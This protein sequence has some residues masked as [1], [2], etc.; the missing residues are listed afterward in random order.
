MTLHPSPR[1]AGWTRRSFLQAVLGTLSLLS[2]GWI[3][4]RVFLPR[5]LRPPEVATLT[6]LVETLLPD[7]E[8]PGAVRTNVMAALLAEPRPT[9]QQRR[10]LVEG[11]QLL[12]SEARRRGAAG[13]TELKPEQR[14]DVVD[15][16]ARAEEGTLPRFFYRIVRDRAM[17]L[18]YANPI[19]WA[20]VRFPHPPQ[21][22]GYPA[23]WQKPDV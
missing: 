17:Q 12:D 6:V 13:F 3:L 7:G 8:F 19:A 1:L 5:S 11:V 14:L 15:V 16:C 18:H 21:P 22:Q 23:Y 10:A 20:A 2:G 9:R 4:K